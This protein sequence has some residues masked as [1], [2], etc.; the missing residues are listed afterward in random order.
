MEDATPEQL[1]RI[2]KVLTEKYERKEPL[3]KHQEHRGTVAT[4]STMF[5]DSGFEAVQSFEEKL[6]MKF[7]NGTAFLN[8]Y[9][10]KLGWLASWKAL[11]PAEILSD[12]DKINTTI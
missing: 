2:Q 1:N 8:H 6:E 9:F 4:V 5:T 12:G 7:A 11:I 3:I 10:V